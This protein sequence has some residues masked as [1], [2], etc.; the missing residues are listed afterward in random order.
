M[1]QLVPACVRVGLSRQLRE[2]LRLHPE[3]LRQRILRKQVLW[4]VWFD[5]AKIASMR[6]RD[7]QDTYWYHNLDLREMLAIY[8]ILPRKFIDDSD[9]RK[10]KW[11]QTF[12]QR[13]VPPNPNSPTPTHA[14]PVS[15]C[16]YFA[17]RVM[18]QARRP[19]RAA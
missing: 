16:P 5:T 11:L 15:W 9:G 10:K 7:L 19:D 12:R 14:H 8:A 4:L 3:E 17:F 6:Y 18:L 2:E 13:C 1:R